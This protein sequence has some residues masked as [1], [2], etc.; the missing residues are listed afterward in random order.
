MVEH[1][2]VHLVPERGVEHDRRAIDREPSRQ[3]EERPGERHGAHVE[4]PLRHPERD[5][6]AEPARSL[7]D[8]GLIGGDRVDRWRQA[9]ERHDLPEG[10][11]CEHRIPVH[12]DDHTVRIGMR[13]DDLLHGRHERRPLSPL[14]P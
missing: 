14:L 3:A 2:A 12:E 6:L 7:D 13:G 1:I 11:G 5:P 4:M 9:K 8:P 10:P